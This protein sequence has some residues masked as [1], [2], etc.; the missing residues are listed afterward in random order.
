MASPQAGGGPSLL[1][2]MLSVVAG[3]SVFAIFLVVGALAM[4]RRNE[5]EYYSTDE[6]Q[7]PETFA[8]NPETSYSDPL[9]GWMSET[10]P[11]VKELRP[12][13]EPTK[14][15]NHRNQPDG[16]GEFSEDLPIPPAEVPET[17][18][19]SDLAEEGTSWDDLATGESLEPTPREINRW[20]DPESEKSSQDSL[21]SLE[22]RQSEESESASD[23][24]IQDFLSEL[25][26]TE[27]EPLPA[28]ASSGQQ[29]AS[30]KTESPELEEAQ[31][32]PE[33]LPITPEP[34]VE[35]AASEEQL[36]ETEE[37]SDS[38]SPNP[39]VAAAESNSSSTRSRKKSKRR[40]GRRRRRR[41]RPRK[42]Q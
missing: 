39:A 37:K 40:S 29:V 13:Q 24:A 11:P 3:L 42:S 21:P 18:S 35:P 38:G 8:A 23:P 36:P 9:L 2:I 33:P 34:E 17:E 16:F 19:A 6:A 5:E 32:E 25:E 41:S 1:T 31:F 10:S 14:D 20:D 30:S 26:Q 12:V 22:S 27:F 15:E 7:E 28:W 4:R